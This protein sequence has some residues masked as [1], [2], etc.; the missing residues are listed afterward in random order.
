MWHF[1][2]DA[3]RGKLDERWD[4]GVWL[5][6]SLSDDAHLIATPTGVK[7]AKTIRHQEEGKRWNREQV[8]ALVAVPWPRGGVRIMTS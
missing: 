2:L 3:K 1:Q 7:Q 6:K 4:D 8:L 5:G